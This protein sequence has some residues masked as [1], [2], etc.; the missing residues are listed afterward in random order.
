MAYET[1]NRGS[2]ARENQKGGD[3][4]R[5]SGRGSCERPDEART[6]QGEFCMLAQARSLE[7]TL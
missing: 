1:V 4:R 7:L 6:I 3:G 2:E 5:V